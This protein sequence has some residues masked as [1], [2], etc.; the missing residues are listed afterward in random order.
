[1]TLL[2]NMLKLALRADA[3]SVT[4]MVTIKILLAQNAT[5]TV[6]YG[7]AMAIALNRIP[8]NRP[9]TKQPNTN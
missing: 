1:M 7:V 3:A 5:V 9:I 2:A 8:Y 6:G 4:A